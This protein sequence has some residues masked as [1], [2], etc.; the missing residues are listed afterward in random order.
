MHIFFYEIMS[1]DM[2]YDRFPFLASFNRIIKKN[3]ILWKFDK[4]SSATT[5]I[6]TTKT[7]TKS[8]LRTLPQFL[9]AFKNGS[10]IQYHTNEIEPYGLG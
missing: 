6:T 7:K 8:F 9:L 5:T 1:K 2:T 10:E 4:K 3:Q